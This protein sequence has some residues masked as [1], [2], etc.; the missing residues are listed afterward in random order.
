M[1]PR[2]GRDGKKAAQRQ[3]Q[4]LTCLAQAQDW[5]NRDG[6]MDQLYPGAA[7]GRDAIARD[8]RELRSFGWQIE[9]RGEG[10]QMQWRLLGQ[11]PR[12][13]TQLSPA[14]LLALSRAVV[15]GGGDPV[16]LGLDRQG[17]RPTAAPA[18]PLDAS[19][20]EALYLEEVLHA[21]RY[22]CLLTL[23]Y[24][25]RRRTLHLDAVVRTGTGRWRLHGR[26]D[27]APDAAQKTFRLDRIDWL[28][29]G[30]PNSASK[31][32]P[33]RRDSNPLTFSDG[34]PVVAEVLVG[35]E[36]EDY[37]TRQLGPPKHREQTSDGV[38]LTIPVRNRWLWR[39]RLYQ[40]GER[41][42]L[43][44][45]DDL[46]QEVRHELLAFTGDR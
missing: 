11:D 37:V 24:N 6:L 27:A 18:S 9:Q 31:P 15:L 43:L 46:C 35:A 41:V 21:W 23:D 20:R 12:L 25:K 38:Y 1:P 39:M 5:V 8:R 44:G 14:Q 3:L 42:R 36:H 4:L 33:V 34:D 13:R 16:A 28:R 26:Q 30:P 40:L 19:L 10:A 17:T 45:P 32:Q 29:V 7:A 2:P 22:H